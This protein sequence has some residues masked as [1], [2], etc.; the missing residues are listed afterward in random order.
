[1]LSLFDEAAIVEPVL[2]IGQFVLVV[3]GWHA[4]MA[5]MTVVMGKDLVHKSLDRVDHEEA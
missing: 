5:M 1:M 3:D 4:V 2:L